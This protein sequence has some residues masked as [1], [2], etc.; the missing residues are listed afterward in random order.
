MAAAWLGNAASSDAS[1]VMASINWRAPPA[2]KCSR[3]Q[4]NKTQLGQN[5]GCMY[6]RRKRDSSG[7]LHLNRETKQNCSA[8]LR[9]KEKN[10]IVSMSP[11]H[12]V[13]CSPTST[14]SAHMSSLGQRNAIALNHSRNFMGSGNFE[15]SREEEMSFLSC[16]K[17]PLH[18][19]NIQEKQQS[20][21]ACGRA[22]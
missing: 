11:L 22:I 20:K 4:S 12:R 9:G 2:S 5:K 21:S 10:P 1:R 3:V 8:Y 16:G 13:L 14:N 6:I 7:S 17:Q 19:R 18:E 15:I